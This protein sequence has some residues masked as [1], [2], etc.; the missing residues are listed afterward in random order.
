[1]SINEYIIEFE[2]LN[3]KMIQHQMKLRSTVLTFKLLDGA[4]IT[5]EERKLALTLCSDSDFDKMKSA[6]K[7]L[8]TTSSNHSHSQNNIVA[9]KQEE[10]FF[11]KKHKKLNDKT[12]PLDENGKISRCIICDSKSRWAKNC[13]HRSSQN[14]NIVEGDSETEECNIVLM[15]ENISKQEIFV[16]EAASSTIIDTAAQKQLHENVGL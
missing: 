3:N 9:I 4:D 14:I 8:F 13:P 2:H 16:M 1:M 5:S 10:A 6:L 11:N 7:R 12:N 15:T